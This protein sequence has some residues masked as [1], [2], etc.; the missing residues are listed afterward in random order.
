MN[1]G[2]ITGT[3]AGIVTPP[4]IPMDTDE[5]NFWAEVERF[6]GKADEAYTL[7]QRLRTKRQAAASNAA[8]NTE[9]NDVMNEGE[10]IAAKISD[11]E[12]VTNQVKQGMAETI[13]GW[14]GL[15]GVNHLKQNLGQLGFIQIAA[16]ALVTGA[17]A[18]LGSWIVKGNI[19][20]RKLTAVENMIAGGVSPAQAGTGAFF[21]VRALR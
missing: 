12:R 13:G 7:W 15:E 1:L 11:V 5:R 17:I 20:D 6:K 9:Y 3:G 16:L 10:R 14:F 8:L 18:W 4:D 21:V 19:V 2:A